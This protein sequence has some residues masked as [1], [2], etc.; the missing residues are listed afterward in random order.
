MHARAGGDTMTHQRAWSLR[1]RRQ[2]KSTAGAPSRH[3][4]PGTA[5]QA[6]VSYAGTCTQA[7]ALQKRPSLVCH[8][9]VQPKMKVGAS[10]SCSGSVRSE[11]VSIVMFGRP[12]SARANQMLLAGPAASMH[13]RR[14]RL[15]RT[16]QRLANSLRKAVCNSAGRRKR[17]LVMVS[18][19]FPKV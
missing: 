11:R 17:G 6:Y 3:V 9:G 10:P 15:G 18:C 4:T 1:R 14:G 19:S 16:E 2:K 5:H 8:Q 7:V 13:Y 12:S